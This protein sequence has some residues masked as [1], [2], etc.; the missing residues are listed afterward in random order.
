MIPSRCTPILVP[1]LFVDAWLLRGYEP[2]F[3][4]KCVRQLDIGSILS[5]HPS[6]PFA[7][8][9]AFFGVTLM[10]Q[11]QN[12]SCIHSH[13]QQEHF[14]QFTLPT[15]VKAP[16]ESIC[17][18]TWICVAGTCRKICLTWICAGI[19]PRVTCTCGS[20]SL[21]VRSQVVMLAHGL[22]TKVHPQGPV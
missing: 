22:D 15:T 7:A 9:F 12:V 14:G 6:A 11:I 1:P 18:S 5:A 17:R 16:H 19:F 8:R 4:I 3:M 2:C 20:R 21:Q 10:I 13:A